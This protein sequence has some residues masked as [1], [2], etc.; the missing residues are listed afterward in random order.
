[1]SLFSHPDFDD[2]EQVVFC[3]NADCG[4]SAII[5]VHNTKLGVRLGHLTALGEWIGAVLDPRAV[6]HHA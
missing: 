4:L 6:V 1:M 3:R 2:H 5:A